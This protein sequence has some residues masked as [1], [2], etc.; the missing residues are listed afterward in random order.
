[1]TGFQILTAMLAGLGVAF[2]VILLVGVIR[3]VS[4]YKWQ[5]R[6]EQ[7]YADEWVRRHRANGDPSPFPVPRHR[8][9]A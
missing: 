5:K 4:E 7:Q 3:G 8:D 9:G 1:M 6:R 2:I